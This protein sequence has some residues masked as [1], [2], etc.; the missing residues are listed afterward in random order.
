[1]EFDVELDQQHLENLSATTPLTGVVELI[2]NALDADATEVKVEFGRGALGG[3]EDIRVIDNGH[4]MSFD[5]AAETFKKLGGSW[6][7]SAQGSKSQGRALHGRDGKGR[8]RAAG[9]GSRMIW[10]TVAADPENEDRRLALSITLEMAKLAHVEITN[11]GETEEPTGTT[12]LIDGIVEPPAG[13]G[14][15]TPV[16]KLTGIF[17]LYLQNYNA[18]LVFDR[19]EIDPEKLQAHRAEYPIPVTGADDALLTIIEWNRTVE[20]GLFLCDDQ[21]TPLAEQPPGIQAAGFDFTA[22]VAWTGFAKD[23][24]LTLADLG[25]GDTKA[26]LEAARDELRK[27]FHM[28]ADE[29]TRE[30][31]EE[32]KEEKVYPFSEEP[33]TPAEEAAQEVFDVVA[34]AASNVVNASDH[35]GRRLSLRLLREALETDPGSLHHV[36]QEVLDLPQDRLDELSEL[37][38]ATPLTA[39][40]ATSKEIANRLEFLR[41][42][43][44]LAIPKDVAKLVKERS[45]L[46]RILANET[47]VFGEEYAL[48]AD[49]ETLT[50]ALKRHIEILG[51][52]DISVD[53]EVTDHEGRRQVVDLM[54]AR[55]LEQ[56]RNRREHL[57]V[58]LKAPSVPVGDTEAGQIKKY[59]AA[60]AADDRFNK[61]D[62]EWDFVVISTRVT[63]T[64]EMERESSDR[65]DGQIFNSKGIRVWVR[66]WAEI[67]EGA[68]H[69]LKFVKDHLGYQP[70]EQ[71][72]LEYLRKT[73]AKYLPPELA[74]T[75]ANTD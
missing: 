37:L 13:L 64:V 56:H 66:T 67:I 47:W 54:L 33:E 31:I 28:R 1:M 43:E 74:T 9:I 44:E 73:H 60:V 48:A 70:E 58:E 23:S 19:E 15:E 68:K 57:V 22:Y 39:L 2:W 38:Q 14:G 18:H 5:E 10:K 59:A 46:H 26:V 62:V 32:W 36:L 17:G 71:R 51:R 75:A 27:H 61:L 6:K 24:E 41:G 20:R 7:R 69:R 12:V 29:R 34:L 4:G 40:I 63:G 45:Q 25:H 8:F 72:A 11:A 65:P 3:V 53:E 30:Q 55:S 16:E 50:T 49:D 21:G 42:L 52:E 35:R